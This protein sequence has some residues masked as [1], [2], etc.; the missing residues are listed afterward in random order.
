[1]ALFTI[2]W[3]EL[4]Q[5]HHQSYRPV[6]VTKIY[7]ARLTSSILNKFFLFPQTLNQAKEVNDTEKKCLEESTNIGFLISLQKRKRQR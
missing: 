1:M 5:R 3:K 7:K 2:N 4:S 6:K